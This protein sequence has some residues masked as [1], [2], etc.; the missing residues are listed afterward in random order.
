MYQKTI[1][2]PLG[3]LLAISDEKALY[4][5]RFSKEVG[6]DTARPLKMIE[7]ELSE[8]FAG[9]LTV[10]KTPL[11]PIGT[12][13]QRLVWKELCN[14]PFGT[15]RSYSEMADAIGKPTSV[16]AAANAN[17]KNPL[18]IVIPCHRVV[19]T[20]GLLGGY[21]LGIEKKQWLLTHEEKMLRRI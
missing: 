1:L 2:T 10:F 4:E 6:N 11:S 21:S 18:P 14:I 9:N 13:F 3:P 7:K 20:G 8:Y 15:T 16:R 19:R 17:G 5:L 12:A